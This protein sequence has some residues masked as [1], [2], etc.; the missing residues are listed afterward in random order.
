M[1][2]L[3]CNEEIPCSFCLAKTDGVFVPAHTC[4]NA[5]ESCANNIGIRKLVDICTIN[6][7]DIK[8]TV[9]RRIRIWEGKKCIMAI[10]LQ[11]DAIVTKPN[12]KNLKV[13]YEAYDMPVYTEYKF[14][15]ND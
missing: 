12:K 2:C 10:D 1:K 15:T 13:T 4:P 14:N 5:H 9:I 3:K 11:G 7:S 8:L 6:S